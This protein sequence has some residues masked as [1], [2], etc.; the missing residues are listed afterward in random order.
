MGQPLSRATGVS[1]LRQSQIHMFQIA[2]SLEGDTP[3]PDDHGE[4]QILLDA[5]QPQPKDPISPSLSSY[6][7]DVFASLERDPKGPWR[8][9]C[10]A[11]QGFPWLP[12]YR[13]SSETQEYPSR[14]SSPCPYHLW[15]SSSQT[16]PSTNR[17]L[18]PRPEPNV[19]R[20]LASSHSNQAMCLQEHPSQS[21]PEHYSDRG[22]CLYRHQT[23][24]CFL[25]PTARCSTHACCCYRWCAEYRP[26]T[27]S[28]YP[29]DYSPTYAPHARAVN[30]EF[31]SHAPL[32]LESTWRLHF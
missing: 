27:K 1:G 12:K 2:S 4:P 26:Y 11:A 9:Y 23:Y 21:R 14:S 6:R 10:L 5:D 15:S 22:R 3:R 30:L 7:A 32:L 18:L 19:P 29:D 8:E 17:G 16:D 25:G 28:R 13:R 24:P 20:I 31:Q